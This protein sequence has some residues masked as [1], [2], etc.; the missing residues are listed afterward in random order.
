MCQVSRRRLRILHCQETQRL[1]AAERRDRGV[2]ECVA[3]PLSVATLGFEDGRQCRSAWTAGTGWIA[4]S[5]QTVSCAC[6]VPRAA[7]IP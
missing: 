5:M 2:G 1:T 6:P 4:S 7:E 3:T